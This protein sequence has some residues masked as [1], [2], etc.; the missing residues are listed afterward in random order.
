MRIL[1]LLAL[2]T[3]FSCDDGDSS[4]YDCE[5]FAQTLIDCVASETQDEFDEKVDTCEMIKDRDRQLV[6]CY[7]AAGTDCTMF[8]AC[9]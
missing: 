8:L 9:Q 2:A 1:M 4:S 7:E 3:L 6:D 5:V